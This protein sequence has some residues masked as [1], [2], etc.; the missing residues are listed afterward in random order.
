MKNKRLLYFVLA[1]FIAWCVPTVSN[2]GPGLLVM[3]PPLTGNGAGPAGDIDSEDGQW[4]KEIAAPQNETPL[5]HELFDNIDGSGGGVNQSLAIEG[6]IQNMQHDGN[7]DLTGFEI[8]ATIHNDNYYTLEQTWADG[9]NL[10]GETLGAPRCDEMKM[11]DVKLVIEFADDLTL[12]FPAGGS[13]YIGP[14]SDI[15]ASGHDY[16]AWY[17]WKP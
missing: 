3:P 17:C 16:L 9:S 11:E 2:A 4:F 15:K 7:G 1:L 13:P 14:E 10:H 8:L 5:S 12:G 6:Y